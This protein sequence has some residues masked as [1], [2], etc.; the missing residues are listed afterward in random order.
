MDYKKF[1]TEKSVSYDFEKISENE[2]I[3]NKQGPVPNM[4][5]IWAVL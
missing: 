4:D 1:V 3:K 2:I 5:N